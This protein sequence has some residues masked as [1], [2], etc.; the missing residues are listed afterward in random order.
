MLLSSG[1]MR[2]A[3]RAGGVRVR[4]RPKRVVVAMVDKQDNVGSVW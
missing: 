3:A 4:V 2:R 1:V